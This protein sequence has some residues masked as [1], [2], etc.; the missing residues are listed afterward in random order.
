M[1]EFLS[2]I[3]LIKRTTVS[4]R[5]AADFVTVVCEYKG[6]IV[7]Y[8]NNLLKFDVIVAHFFFYQLFKYESV[9]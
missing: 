3:D 9:H 5:D 4:Q 7:F 1:L 6:V 8:V 2:T